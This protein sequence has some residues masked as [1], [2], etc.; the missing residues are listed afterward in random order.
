MAGT[1][2]VHP[3]FA[4]PLKYLRIHRHQAM[5][6]NTGGLLDTSSFT[7]GIGPIWARSGFRNS[8]Y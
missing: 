2:L 4:V 6:A 3:D 1:A 8:S 7:M 5:G